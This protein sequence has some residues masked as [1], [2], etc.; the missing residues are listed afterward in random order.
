MNLKNS[1]LGFKLNL[2]RAMGSFK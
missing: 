1:K 2:I